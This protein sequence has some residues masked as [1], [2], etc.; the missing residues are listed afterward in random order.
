MTIVQSW[1]GRRFFLE[2]ADQHTIDLD[3]P[4]RRWLE[5]RRLDAELAAVGHDR[6]RLIGKA[7]KLRSAVERWQDASAN[8]VRALRNATVESPPQPPPRSGRGGSDVSDPTLARIEATWNAVDHACVTYAH[9][10]GPCAADGCHIC[11]GDR[12]P[13]SLTAIANALGAPLD[14]AVVIDALLGTPSSS[15][16]AFDDALDSAEKAYAAAADQLQD[17]WHEARR[18]GADDDTLA[19]LVDRTSNVAA[20][21]DGL[22][23]AVT[24]WLPSSPV[25]RCAAGCGGAAPPVGKGATCQHCRDQRRDRSAS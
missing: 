4:S 9:L 23:G 5:Q 17:A 1:I 22:V 10:A 16:A 14:L 12:R 3:R 25:R 6:R 20:R 13:D 7:R 24:Q 8:V 15:T 21:M 2:L 19:T 11:T 18:A